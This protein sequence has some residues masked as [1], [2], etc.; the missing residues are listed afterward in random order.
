MTDLGEITPK[1]ELTPEQ[2]AAIKDLEEFRKNIDEK[3]AL[4]PNLDKRLRKYRGFAYEGGEHGI[5]DDAKYDIEDIRN[6]KRLI[7]DLKVIGF[8]GG[9][10]ISKDGKYTG[11]YDK[12]MYSE[13]LQMQK[14][15]NKYLRE[16]KQNVVVVEATQQ[17]KNLLKTIAKGKNLYNLSGTLKWTGKMGLSYEVSLAAGEINGE[18]IGHIKVKDKEGALIKDIAFRV[19]KNGKASVSATRLYQ[20]LEDGYLGVETRRAVGVYLKKFFKDKEESLKESKKLPE[21][22]VPI[23]PPQA[24]P[25]KTNAVI[26]VGYSFRDDLEDKNNWNDVLRKLRNLGDYEE[27]ENNIQKMEEIRLVLT[28]ISYEAEMELR[29]NP[30]YV[31]ING[32]DYS[33]TWEGAMLARR[34]WVEYSTFFDRWMKYL[35]TNEATKDVAKKVENGTIKEKGQRQ[36]FVVE[37]KNQGKS[38][39][40]AN[41]GVSTADI[42]TMY[43]EVV[44]NINKYI[45]GN[46]EMKKRLLADIEKEKKEVIGLI[47]KTRFSRPEELREM[48]NDNE[49]LHLRILATYGAFG[50]KPDEA[51]ILEMPQINFGFLEANKLEQYIEEV[52]GNN[53]EGTRK[54]FARYFY[55]SN[56]FTNFENDSAKDLM[57]KFI[58]EFTTINHNNRR[59]LPDLKEIDNPEM[60]AF[61]MW[62][63]INILHRYN[64]EILKTKKERAEPQL[65]G[66]RG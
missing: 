35:K 21:T 30:P 45:S 3:I 16:N 7:D 28:N 53:L 60:K 38:P 29:R 13:V 66:S 9:E 37:V 61:V 48:L 6:A 33:L 24:V 18:K 5:T 46:G 27:L 8:L 59:Y 51:P 44:D 23:V 25:Q 17:E 34:D 62:I 11:K 14:S 12:R 4:D 63:Y 10:R 39:K 31:R 2:I 20:I 41:Y 47:K 56:I 50:N 54:L 15:I 40:D 42:E 43:N 36:R 26:S 32:K 52:I 49:S 19:D 65:V 58:D 57:E 1:K 55:I 64:Q 22:I